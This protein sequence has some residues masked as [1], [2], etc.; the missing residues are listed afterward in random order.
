MYMA[1]WFKDEQDAKTFQRE[2]GGALYK[3]TPRSRTR[4]DHLTT[5]AMMGFD[6][7]EFK[8]SVNWT[9]PKGEFEI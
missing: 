2:H 3:N 9:A 5:A 6:P 8:F 7:D 4:I 1:K